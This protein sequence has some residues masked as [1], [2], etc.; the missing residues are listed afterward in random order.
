MGGVKDL[1]GGDGGGA[2]A[3]ETDDVV[4]AFAF[5]VVGDR[6]GFDVVCPAVAVAIVSVGGGVVHSDRTH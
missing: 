4:G 1:S 6:V 2:G 5:D 3:W